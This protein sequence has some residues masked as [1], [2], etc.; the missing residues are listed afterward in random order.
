[1]PA[2]ATVCTAGIAA[3]RVGPV[4][5]SALS[6]PAVTWL[7][8]GPVYAKELVRPEP[9][10]REEI[11]RI[12]AEYDEKVSKAQ[13]DQFSALSNQFDTEAQVNK[14]EN[15]YANYSIRNGM[16]YIKAPQSGYVNRAL[17]SGLGETVK[18]GTPIV[19]IM[20]SQ[21][22]IAVETFV[23]PIDLP[24]LHRGEKIRVWFAVSQR[25]VGV[26]AGDADFLCTHEPPARPARFE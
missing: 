20:P 22:D 3:I 18:E 21:Y 17:Q 9:A 23:D 2:S 24:L 12:K 1:M 7:M 14:L 5:A 10:E 6:L 4:T 8:A 16:Y 26:D 19:S 13:S 11:N 25:I 15:Q